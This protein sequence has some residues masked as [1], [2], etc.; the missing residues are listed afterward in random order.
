MATEVD[1]LLHP[2]VDRFVI[3]PIKYDEIWNMY[4]LA[5]ASFWTAEEIDL[6]VDGVHWN[7]GLTPKEKAYFSRILGFF[8]GADGIVTE[9]L[10]SRFSTEVQIPEARFFYGFQI[11]MENIHAEIYAQILQ[12]VIT[13]EEERVKLMNS[14]VTIDSIRAKADWCLQ[15]INNDDAPFAVRLVAF[16]AVEGI[17]FSSSFAA[18]FWLRKRGILPGITLSNEFICRDEGLHTEFACLLH[19]NLMTKAETSVIRQIVGEAVDLE[20]R[21]NAAID[22]RSRARTSDD[23]HIQRVSVCADSLKDP[24]VGLNATLMNTYIECVGNR[25]MSML[26]QGPLFEGA[27]NPFP[28]MEMISL[29]GKTNFFERRVSEYSKS[30][31]DTKRGL[32]NQGDKKMSMFHV[33][34]I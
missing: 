7:N 22:V 26:G 10:V 12:T 25:L 27:T 23:I 31:I 30:G 14:I 34:E 28:F 2:T 8:A 32:E 13:A 16:A 15:W 3:F 11:M 19:A 6:S 4:K 17:F 5:Q 29:Q 33:A 24:F 1:P 20:K 9:N 21:F 18:I